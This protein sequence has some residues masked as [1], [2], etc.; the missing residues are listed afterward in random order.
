MNIFLTNSLMVS[1]VYW[2]VFS[3]QKTCVNVNCLILTSN[4][5]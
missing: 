5:S 4:D 1:S 3:K 2:K